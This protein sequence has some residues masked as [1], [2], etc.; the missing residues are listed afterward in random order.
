[1]TLTCNLFAKLPL[2]WVTFVDAFPGAASQGWHCRRR[3]AAS[4][5]KFT[6][7]FNLIFQKTQSPIWFN[8]IYT[9]YNDIVELNHIISGS[10]CTQLQD[11]LRCQRLELPTDALAKYLPWGCFKRGPKLQVVFTESQPSPSKFGRSL[12]LRHNHITWWS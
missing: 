8:N 10:C 4:K 12:T 9:L 5:R 3:A 2:S 6:K 11:R 7:P 1:M